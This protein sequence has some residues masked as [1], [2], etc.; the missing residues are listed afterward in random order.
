MSKSQWG[1]LFA[2]IILAGIA[3]FYKNSFFSN[4]KEFDPSAFNRELVV[5]SNAVDWDTKPSENELTK[6]TLGIS[7]PILKPDN[8]LDF[9]IWFSTSPVIIESVLGSQLGKL[10]F[11]ITNQ[12]VMEP[13]TVH[14]SGLDMST[15]NPFEPI[16]FI[17]IYEY[18]SGVRARH[19]VEFELK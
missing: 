4:P 3:G 18:N 5:S 10:V 14:I 6:Y 12:T 19:T 9:D 8:T 16:T 13:D 11:Q 15:F 2:V 7:N 17:F 1:G